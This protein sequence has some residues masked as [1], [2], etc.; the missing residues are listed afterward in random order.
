[1][2]HDY[3][4]EARDLAR[5]WLAADTRVRVA[6]RALEEAKQE[7]QGLAAD[8]ERVLGVGGVV[9]LPDLD[10]TFEVRPGRRTVDRRAVEAHV[11][12]LPDRCR[13]REQMQVVWPAVADIEACSALI[14][15]RGVDPEALVQ[16]GDPTVH[17][18][19]HV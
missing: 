4:E 14:R 2:S 7:R 6:E 1:M 12:V 5:E 16:R 13:P 11:E 10:M 17:A 18:R 19:V 15:A 3:V 9:E 8:L